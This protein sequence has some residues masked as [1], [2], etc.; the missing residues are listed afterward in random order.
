METQQP[1]KRR[2]AKGSE[3]QDNQQENFLFVDSSDQQG[4]SKPDRASRSFVMQQARKQKTWSTKKFPANSAAKR[5]SK[6]PSQDDGPD[7][8][9]SLSWVHYA[10]KNESSHKGEKIVPYRFGGSQSEQPAVC[11]LP[12]CNGDFCSQSHHSPP[13][14]DVL[15]LSPR[16]R[17]RLEIAPIG[18]FDPFNTLPVRADPRSFALINHYCRNLVPL[19]IPL[20]I[21]RQSQIGRDEYLASAVRDEARGAFTHTIMCAAALHRFAMGAGPLNDVLYHKAESI[22]KINANLSDPGFRV[23]D[24]N[25][26]AVFNLL[27]I[28]ESLLGIVSAGGGRPGLA[29]DPQQKLM[30]LNG[31]RAMLQQR[32]GLAG[33]S[34]SRCLQAFILWHSIA[35]SIASFEQP[36]AALIDT[37]GRAYTYTIPESPKY[38]SRSSPVQVLRLLRDLKIDVNLRDIAADVSLLSSDMTSWLD[39]P[40]CP[41]DPVELQKHGF[42]LLQRCLAFLDESIAPKSPLEQSVCLA[43]MIFVI[44]ITQPT[45]VNFKTMISASLPRLREALKKTSIF[46]W[47]DSP[48]ILLWVLTLGTLAAQGSPHMGFFTQYSTVAFA[49]AGIDNNT[50]CDELLARMK[51]CLWQSS[52]MDNAVKKLWVKIGIAKGDDEWLVVDD[53][54]DTETVSHMS[55]PDGQSETTVAS[56]TSTRFFS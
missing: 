26:A 56:L 38:P 9:G 23:H 20:D 17:G 31:L 4:T 29:F 50:S 25:I 48:D 19:M 39:D 21:R 1:R 8:T 7:G 22:S 47:S 54:P 41:L 6:A 5:T 32:G 33:L 37:E 36:Y 27:N 51:M 15:N 24:N 34:S 11:R 2:R 45:D 12:F 10:P 43:I 52:L 3:E 40:K 28:E 55:S 35:H 13:R 14:A 16:G 46:K 30:H 44:R 42:L 18:V 49:D 53:E